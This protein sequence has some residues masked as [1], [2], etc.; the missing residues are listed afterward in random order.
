MRQGDGKACLGAG[1]LVFAAAWAISPPFWPLLTVATSLFLA[2]CIRAKTM[3]TRFI[4]G[5]ACGFSAITA[6]IIY[7]DR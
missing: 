1:T 6:L 3:P 2:G 4:G 5:F 7:S